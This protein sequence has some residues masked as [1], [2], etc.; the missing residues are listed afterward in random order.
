MSILVWF[1]FPSI[2]HILMAFG[3][4][5]QERSD[6]PQTLGCASGRRPVLLHM[7]SPGGSL[8]LQPC[9]H[10]RI[11]AAH[12]KNLEP[13][14]YFFYVSCQTLQQKCSLCCYH[15][16]CVE[17]HI[18]DVVKSC[19]TVVSRCLQACAHYQCEGIFRVLYWLVTLCFHL[20]I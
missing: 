17:F 7:L 15:L 4:D 6:L 9:L 11:C 20:L 5:R 3:Q 2:P 13:G 1:F 10:R 19:R 12:Q 14:F 16:I 18:D 8:F